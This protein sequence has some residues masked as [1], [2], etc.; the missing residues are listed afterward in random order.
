MTQGEMKR[1][2][3]LKTVGGTAA[4]LAVAGPAAAAA[5]SVRVGRVVPADQKLNVAC[6][7]VGGM[8]G[9]DVGGVSGEN[10][11]ALCDVD[12]ARAQ[13]SFNRFPNAKRYKDFRKM[14]IEMD[15]Q[16]DAV[17]VSTPDHMHFPIAMMAMEMGKHVLVQKPMAHTVWE[18]R[19][20]TLAAR[21][22]KVATQMGIQRHSIEGIRLLHE[23]IDAGAIGAVREV[24]LWTNRP[25]WPQGIDRPMDSHP[26]PE[27]LDWNSWL[28]TAPKR[29][30]HPDYAPFKWRGWW[31]FGCGALGDMACHIMDAAY[32]SLDLGFPDTIEAE[33]SGA[34][35]ETA[36]KSSVITYQFPA[37]GKRPGV[38]LVWYDG[39]KMPERPEELE[40][41]RDLPGGI[42]GQ[43][44]IGD[45]GKIMADGYCSG[46]RLIPETKMQAFERPP[47]TIPRSPGHYQEWIAAC[48]GGAPA[49]ANFNYSGPFTEM[50]MLGNLAVRTGKLIKWD[51]DRLRC[52]NVPEANKYVRHPYRVF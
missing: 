27:T 26:V 39:G 14:L 25:I 36:P 38:K 42:G 34:N 52:T 48:K 28:G 18:A 15:D 11:V 29:P 33:S 9:G 8:G 32:W 31:D 12:L 7:G 23:W 51:K 47:K 50:V 10:I 44:F 17:T 1:R 30:Y 45:K 20:M 3:F 6:V 46:P 19:E 43:L 35:E 37:R 41:G 24:H 2:E 40:E 5:P 49:G 22:H 4:A 16:I 21:R 13:G